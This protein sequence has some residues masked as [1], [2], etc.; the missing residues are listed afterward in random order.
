MDASSASSRHST[1]CDG[2]LTTTSTS[3]A[4]RLRSSATEERLER[5]AAVTSCGSVTGLL[6]LLAFRPG[7]RATAPSS[8]RDRRGARAP[9]LRAQRRLVARSLPDDREL[10]PCFG[11]PLPRRR[12]D[13]GAR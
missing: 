9:L 8:R 5:S 11:P 2:S 4:R 13:Q 12:A 1:S 10:E 7:P 6:P 3:L